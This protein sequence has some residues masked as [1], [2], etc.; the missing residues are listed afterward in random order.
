MRVWIVNTRL[1]AVGLVRRL[2]AAI[3]PDGTEE[4]VVMERG[5]E[6]R[7]ERV[8][9]RPWTRPRQLRDGRWAIRAEGRAL[10]RVL[11]RDVLLDGVLVR[12]PSLADAR[13]VADADVGDEDT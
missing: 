3:A 9:A 2:T 8:P 5:R 12:T 6:V 10:A 13:D 7:R 4:R 1:Q 11:D